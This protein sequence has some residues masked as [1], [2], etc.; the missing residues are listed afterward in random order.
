MEKGILI[1]PIINNESHGFAIQAKKFL[2]ELRITNC[3]DVPSGKFKITSVVISSASGQ[4]INENFGGKQFIVDTLN[5]NESKIIKIGETGQFMHGLVDIRLTLQQDDI[6]NKLI[7]L[8]K[9]PFT[10][11][12]T[13]ITKIIGLNQWIDFLY[14]KSQSEHR[15]EISTSWMI[16]L[17]WATAILTLINIII[18][19][20]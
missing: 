14:I 8:Q 18:L 15:Q 5:P 16:K 3:L 10:N 20:F 2:L 19:L 17:T 13:N 7:L 1:E 11:E 12:I 4:N 9:N 6:S